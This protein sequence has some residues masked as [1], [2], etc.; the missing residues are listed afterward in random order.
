[1]I[2]DSLGNVSLSLGLVELYGHIHHKK[3]EF[4]LS[5]HTV[6]NIIGQ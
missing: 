6:H 5:Y 2:R 4:S 3:S 1:M